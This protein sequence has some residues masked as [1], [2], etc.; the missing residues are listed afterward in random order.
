ML[1]LAVFSDIVVDDLLGDRL[2]LLGRDEL[3]ARL[4]NHGENL[5]DFVLLM[6]VQVPQ[7]VGVELEDD[8]VVAADET[9]HKP[10]HEQLDLVLVIGLLQLAEET[11]GEVLGVVKSVDREEVCARDSLGLALLFTLLRLDST[12]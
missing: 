5:T 6:G 3:V 11:V 7:N 2:D 8:Q 10:E 4:N 9:R 12:L 1:V